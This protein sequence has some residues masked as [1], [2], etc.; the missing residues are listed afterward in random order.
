MVIL[1]NLRWAMDESPTLKPG[2]TSRDSPASTPE[3]P[4]PGRESWAHSSRT[5]TLKQGITSREGTRT[6]H[7]SYGL[8]PPDPDDPLLGFAPAPHTHARRN[9]ITADR[10]RAFIAELAACGIV[11][12]AA[13][14]VGCSL[15]AIYR[16]R[17]KPGA[18]EFAAA[19][20]QAVDRGMMR[21]EDG[22]LARAIEGEE[23]MVVSMG[24]V[25]GTE[26]RHN[27]ALVMFFL[28]TR[29]AARYSPEAQLGPDHP[30]YKRVKA[31][32]EAEQ[33]RLS[34]DPARIA[35]VQKSIE[36]KIQGWRMALEQKWEAERRAWIEEHGGVVPEIEKYDR[37]APDEAR[38]FAKRVTEDGED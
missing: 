17:H 33:R 29:R 24:Q 38:G 35:R 5:P 27:E 6:S 16:L 28:R 34:S 30:L 20:E 25:M 22:A 36:V 8:P 23:R 31:E 13:R 18:E 21:L 15:E 9:S 12:E 26:R 4:Q 11:S 10:Q 14:R 19:W 3:D 37:W 7:T 1:C 32:Y 2:I